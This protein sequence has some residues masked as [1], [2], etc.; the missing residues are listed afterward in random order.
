[1]KQKIL[2]TGILILLLTLWGCS[3]K[4]A[5]T[6]ET[7]AA[8]TETATV[9]TQP[10]PTETDAKHNVEIYELDTSEYNYSF[11]K[12]LLRFDWTDMTFALKCFDGSVVTGTVEK[13]EREIICIHEGGRMILSEYYHNEKQVLGDMSFS[14]DAGRAYVTDQLMFCP[15]TDSGLIY[16]FLRAENQQQEITADPDADQLDS[17]KNLYKRS[18]EFRCY[19][20]QKDDERLCVLNIHHYPLEGKWVFADAS[21]T[22]AVAMEEKPDGGI[23]FS[24]GGNQWNFHLEGEDLYYDGGS[25]LIATGYDVNTQTY[26]TAEVPEGALFCAYEEDYLY[27]GLYILP[28]ETLEET[29]ASVQIDTKNQY[30]WINCYDG[31]HL[32]GHYTDK[33][34]YLQFP[35]E[36]VDPYFGTQIEN[37]ELHPNEHSLHVWNKGQKDVW[38]LLIGP[39]EISDSFYFFPVQGVEYQDLS[40]A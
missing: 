7:V 13:G 22:E 19:V 24:Q 10:A 2:C 34:D 12:V 23:V 29:Y 36:V 6:P 14:Y 1:M 17:Y 30:L 26:C 11:E 5:P 31:N 37:V 9:P 27:D 33:G 38:E 4:E 16:R 40:E 21:D 32:E 25:S 35:F 15:Q 28:Y 18:Y 39:G 3:A 20:T 8:Q